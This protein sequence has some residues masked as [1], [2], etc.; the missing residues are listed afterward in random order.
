MNEFILSY[1][2]IH[3]SITPG[4]RHH[5]H[6][7][8]S[9]LWSSDLSPPSPPN[10]PKFVRPQKLRPATKNIHNRSVVNKHLI[11]HE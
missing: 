4:H 1:R 7:I 8:L 9:D 2:Y 5:W 11:G 10:I 6:Q 3:M